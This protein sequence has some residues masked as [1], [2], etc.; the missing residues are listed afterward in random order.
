MDF[1]PGSGGFLNPKKVLDSLEIRPTSVVADFGCGHGYFTI[2]LAKAVG[3]EGQV[4][5]VDLRKDCLEEVKERA[6]SEGLG[7]IETIRGNLEVPGGSKT[8]DD[9]CDVVFLANILFQNQKKQEI[10]VEARRVLKPGGKMIIID[11]EP[12]LSHLAGS[13]WRISPEEI[14]RMASEQRFS[15]ERTFDAGEY[16]YGMIFKKF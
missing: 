4:F 6:V 16:H 10:I 11:W 8:P 7:N 12:T 1:P 9:S 2:P 15:F 5:A 13:G 3:S 14:Q